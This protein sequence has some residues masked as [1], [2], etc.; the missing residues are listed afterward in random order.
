LLNPVDKIYTKIWRLRSLLGKHHADKF[1]TTEFTEIERDQSDLHRLF[2]GNQGPIVHKWKHYL[3][4]YHK[5]FASFRNKTFRLLEIGVFRGG[6]LRLWRQY[7]G[8]NA[9]IFGVDIDP[10]CAAFDGQ[11]AQVRIGSQANSAFLE[12][13]VAE[14]G[15]LDIVID[16]GSHVSSHQRAS[17]NFLFPRLNEGGIYVCEDLHTNYWRG[18]L[19]GGYRRS[20]T[21][22]ESCKRLVDDMHSDFHSRGGSMMSNQIA[23]IHFYNSMIV[24]DKAEQK[25]PSHIKI[26][27]SE[28]SPTDLSLDV[29]GLEQK[30]ESLITPRAL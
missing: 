8:P 22:I 7:F 16:D 14:M 11:D 28:S 29:C 25:T 4:I 15:G 1:E 13:V 2:Y 27:G 19:E 6:S 30:P 10:A 5:H 9:T 21:F 3:E 24:I 12:R 20:S 23:G 26:G 17:F 18:W